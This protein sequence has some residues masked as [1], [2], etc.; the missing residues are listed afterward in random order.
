MIHHTWG[1]DFVCKK[2][3]YSDEYTEAELL[4]K[5]YDSEFVITLD[6][7]PRFD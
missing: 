2:G 4:K 1:G 6:E 3:K 5:V 7:L